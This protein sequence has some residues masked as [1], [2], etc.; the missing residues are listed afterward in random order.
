M[1]ISNFYNLYFFCILLFL[2]GRIGRI[3][4]HT[5]YLFI[6]MTLCTSFFYSIQLIKCILV[7]LTLILCLVS[8]TWT[9]S[10]SVRY[11]TLPYSQLRS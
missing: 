5:L 10:V 8:V 7:F 3:H 1:Y 2:V 6:F 9:L 11:P 4:Y